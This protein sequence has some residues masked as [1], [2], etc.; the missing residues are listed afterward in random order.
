MSRKVH[1]IGIGGA[2]LSA[3]A[4]VLHG[5][6]EVVTG[7]DRNNSP[8]A[9]ALS[10]AGVRVSIG[11]SAANVSGSDLVISSSAI[12]ADNVEL[13]AAKDLG[14]PVMGRREFFDHLTS[15]SKTIA[16]AGTHGKTTTT[17]MV[18][19]ILDQAGVDPSFVVGGLL[20]DFGANGKSGKGEYFIVEADEY[21]NAFLG[22]HPKIAVITNVEHDHPDH[23]PTF[24]DVF[25]AFE[26]FTAQ[27]KETLIVCIDDPGAASLSHES[28]ERIT[29][30]LGPQAYWRAEELRANTAG[31]MD[32]LVLK[33]NDLLGL[34]RTRLPGEHNVSNTLAALAVS[35]ALE[36]P[37]AIS[38]DAMTEFHGAGQRFEILGVVNEITVVDDYAHHPTEIRATLS[39]SK[40]RFPEAEIWTVFQ[41]HTYSRI[42]ALL[43]AY[44]GAFGDAAHV[45]VTDVFGAREEQNG[46]ISGELV[47]SEIEHQDVEY[48]DDFDKIAEFLAQKVQSGDV[49]VTLSAG[50]AN[51]VGRLL[52]LKLRGI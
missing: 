6:G 41:P 15:D 25:A 42:K 24:E 40:L 27:V 8:F 3:L 19:W 28:V 26:K 2:G 37:F 22:L 29:Y 17:G 39:T 31:G 44:R 43:A 36:I 10:E 38:R 13:L 9:Q 14:I 49:V 11:H 32:F 18:A 12:P 1:F 35:D 33:G 4:Y 46:M 30:G 50:D 21:D 48:V 45:I 16:I 5:R 23:F 20:P 47:A 7:S 51:E 52:L 34:V